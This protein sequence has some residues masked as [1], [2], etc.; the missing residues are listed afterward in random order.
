MRNLLL[1]LCFHREL[2]WNQMNEY[3][4]L[5]FFHMLK[6]NSCSS[7]RKK[8]YFML[9]QHR[10]QVRSS[11][12]LEKFLG[13][14]TVDRWY[15]D[16]KNDVMYMLLWNEVSLDILVSAKW[17]VLWLQLQAVN[18]NSWITFYNVNSFVC[19]FSL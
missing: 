19:H 2:I 14:K 5:T 8:I 7:D 17:S 11:E 10:R 12:L 1:K 3:L 13:N 15:N 16:V 4:G 18:I 9:E 6:L